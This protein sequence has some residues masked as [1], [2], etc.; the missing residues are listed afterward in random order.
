MALDITKARRTAA[1]PACYVTAVAAATGQ[2]RRLVAATTTATAAAT[3]TTTVA[4]RSA[5]PATA[6]VVAG[7]WSRTF[8]IGERREYVG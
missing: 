4:N 3:A 7:D 1:L 5:S 8:D 6:A 2:T